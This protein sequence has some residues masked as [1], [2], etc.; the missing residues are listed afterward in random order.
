[1]RCNLRV[2]ALYLIIKRGK[3]EPG[4]PHPHIQRR[5]PKRGSGVCKFTIEVKVNLIGG[6]ICHAGD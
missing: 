2:E 4:S 5:N 1:M 6:R 3:T